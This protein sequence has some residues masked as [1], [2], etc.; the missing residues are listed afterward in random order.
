MNNFWVT[1]RKAV[2]IILFK[3]SHSIKNVKLD[4]RKD[5]NK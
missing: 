3:I 1:N 5:A 4:N 2:W